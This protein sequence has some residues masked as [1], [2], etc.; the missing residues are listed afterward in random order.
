MLYTKQKD[1]LLL[2]LHPAKQSLDLLLLYDL[3]MKKVSHTH[4]M[5][6]AEQPAII[7]IMHTSAL[8][9]ETISQ[10]Q[11]DLSTNKQTSA[12]AHHNRCPLSCVLEVFSNYNNPMILCLRH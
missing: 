12:K 3:A 10:H 1:K 7:H 11:K 8:S 4:H 6:S 5:R 2:G 9:S